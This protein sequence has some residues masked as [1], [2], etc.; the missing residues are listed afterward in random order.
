MFFYS[1]T[2][3]TRLDIYDYNLV[4]IGVNCC[5]Y[6][7]HSVDS[8]NSNK[9]EIFAGNTTIH[10]MDSCRQKQKDPKWRLPQTLQKPR[11]RHHQG[12]EPHVHSL[13]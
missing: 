2:K 1:P 13:M 3:T 7:L 9:S 11:L 8:L 12:Q 10:T 6:A 5:T 4:A